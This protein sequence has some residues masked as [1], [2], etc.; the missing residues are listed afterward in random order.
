MESFYFWEGRI[1]IA[2]HNTVDSVSWV[3]KH[4]HSLDGEDDEKKNIFN[5]SFPHSW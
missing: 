3:S 5:V 1:I 2:V 4:N